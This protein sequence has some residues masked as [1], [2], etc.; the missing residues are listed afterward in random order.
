[1]SKIKWVENKEDD[2]RG[3][4]TNM[5]FMVDNSDKIFAYNSFMTYK[6]FKT[7]TRKF[8]QK[9]ESKIVTVYEDKGQSNIII[10]NRYDGEDESYSFKFLNEIPVEEG[11]KRQFIYYDESEIFNQSK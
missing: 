10:A 1:M 5:C 6:T 2:F 8:A 3:N 4:W 11:Q 9:Y 7:I